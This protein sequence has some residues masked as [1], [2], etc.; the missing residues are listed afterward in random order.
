MLGRPLSYKTFSE[1]ILIIWKLADR[2]NIVDLDENKYL[3]KFVKQ[4]DYLRALLGG[5]WLVMGHYLTVYPWTPYYTWETQELTIVATWV[6]FF[7]MP[8]HVSLGN[9]REMINKNS[10]KG[11]GSKFNVLDSSE[12]N[13]DDIVQCEGTSYVGPVANHNKSDKGVKFFATLPFPTPSSLGP[14]VD[15]VSFSFFWVVWRQLP[16]PNPASAK[17]STFSSS[18]GT[19]GTKK[20]YKVAAVTLDISH[21]QSMDTKIDYDETTHKE[22]SGME[23]SFEKETISNA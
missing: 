3:V 12:D 5:P 14:S 2:Y 4:D 20:S 11:P 15:R 8:L 18:T 10:L 23:M 16:A 6:R 9:A 21:V 19:N 13:E 22:Q 17:P 7:G 1:N